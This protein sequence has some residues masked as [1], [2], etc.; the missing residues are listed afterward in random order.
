MIFGIAHYYLRERRPTREMYHPTYGLLKGECGIWSGTARINGR[1]VH[2]TVAGS[3]SAPDE[4][5]L[6]R[7]GGII[8]RF[9]DVERQAAEHLRK[10]EVEIGKAA[11][12]IYGMDVTEGTRPDDF[13]LEFLV[14]G[15]DSRVWRVEFQAGQPKRTGFD[16]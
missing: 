6:G 9:S 2:F 13:T 16:D 11:L 5:S 10:R 8:G 7:V 3:D 12:E 14:H 15:D 4:Q 1:E